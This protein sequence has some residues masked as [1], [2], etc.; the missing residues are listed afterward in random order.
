MRKLISLVLIM[1]SSLSMFGQNSNDGTSDTLII[2][3]NKKLPSDK[4]IEKMLVGKWKDENST[5][6]FYKNRTYLLNF[7]TGEKQEG[8]WN[9]NNSL[10][11]FELFRPSGI[12]KLRGLTQITQ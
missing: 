4:M 8:F 3:R 10:L 6:F 2:Y 7:D 9:I 5:I 11:T 1:F 12:F